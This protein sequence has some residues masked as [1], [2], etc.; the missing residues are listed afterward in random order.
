DRGVI[1]PHSRGGVTLV[2]NRDP[3]PG[4]LRYA[5]Q[6]FAM[7][8]RSTAPLAATLSHYDFGSTI[9]QPFSGNTSQTWVFADSDKAANVFDFIVWYNPGSDNA[10]VTVTLT[11]QSGTQLPPLTF[12]T[13]RFRRGGI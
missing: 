7:E 2:E 12:N 13:D 11:D 8:L 6:P 3:G 9:A 1:A 5:N 10:V 4:H